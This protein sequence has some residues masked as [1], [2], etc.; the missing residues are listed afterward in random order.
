MSANRDL[1]G[2]PPENPG[3][4]AYTPSVPDMRIPAVI[5][6]RHEEKPSTSIRKIYTGPRTWTSLANETHPAFRYQGTRSLY[7]DVE[8]TPDPGLYDVSAPRTKA[9]GDLSSFGVRADRQ[10]L[11]SGD[12]NPGPGT[13]NVTGEKWIKRRKETVRHAVD[14]FD[15]STVVPGPGAYDPKRPPRGE[16]AR[17]HSVFASGTARTTS[18]KT[19]P[20]GP[21]RY[22]PGWVGGKVAPKI[23]QSRFAKHGDFIQQGLIETPAPDAYQKIEMDAGQGK[24]IPRSP[25]LQPMHKSDAPGPGTY[26][27]KHDSLLKR[28]RNSSIPPFDLQSYD[29]PL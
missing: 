28:S 15:P 11:H 7:P 26:E 24:T 25:R 19:I 20:P 9:A 12:D 16:R 10:P 1:Y 6:N 17:P 4:G 29:L 22:S 21:G 14:R 13:Y 18:S 27:V 2:S 23:H 5:A 8:K 3:P